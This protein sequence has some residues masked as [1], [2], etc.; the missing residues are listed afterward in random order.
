MW[1][2]LH[3]GRH[4]SQFHRNHFL[5]AITANESLVFKE[6]D[7]IT[8]RLSDRL[9]ESISFSGLV[10]RFVA[11]LITTTPAPAHERLRIIFGI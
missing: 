3:R 9:E 8:S 4:N 11:S 5:F 7:V 10:K 1:Q 6:D 2:Y